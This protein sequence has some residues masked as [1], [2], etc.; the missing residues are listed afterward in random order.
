MDEG[1]EDGGQ[2]ETEDGAMGG[3]ESQ[4]GDMWHAP[5]TDPPGSTE[6]IA[7]PSSRKLS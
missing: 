7:A 5:L 1:G 6:Y 2:L 3:G 4:A